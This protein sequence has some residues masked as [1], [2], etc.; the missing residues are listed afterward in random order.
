MKQTATVLIL[1]L[2]IS[3]GACNEAANENVPNLASVTGKWKLA[4]TLDDPGDGSGQWTP[5]KKNE[6]IYIKFNTDGSFESSKPSSIKSYRVTD[7]V[8]IE[9]T[10]EDQTT[11][12][13][14]YYINRSILML[15]PPCDE[16]CSSR[17]IK[18]E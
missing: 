10:V 16:P 15:S 9:F 14:R 12:Q 17:Y 2:A 8:T 1:V 18:I 4:E 13:Y 5:V 7:S 3:F 6:N 11:H